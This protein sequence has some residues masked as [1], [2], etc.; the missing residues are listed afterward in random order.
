MSIPTA[1]IDIT[2]QILCTPAQAMSALGCGKTFLYSLLSEGAI[3][4]IKVGK[5]RMLIVSS[6][7]E[8]VLSMQSY[9][10]GQLGAK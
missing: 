1:N 5:K 4:S 9:G 3:D 8:W 6:I 2:Q 7:H 10:I